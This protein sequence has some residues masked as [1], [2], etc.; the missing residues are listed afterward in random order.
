MS[1][2]LSRDTLFNREERKD[3]KEK[4]RITPI[5]NSASHRVFN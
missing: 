2:L 5:K 3:K 4:R 1:S